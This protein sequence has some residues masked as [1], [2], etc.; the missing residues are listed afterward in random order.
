MTD[1]KAELLMVADLFQISGRGLVVMP[2]FSVPAHW[3]ETQ[4]DA[5]ILLPNGNSMAARL[6]LTVTH[7]NIPDLE[8]PSDLRWRVTPTFPDLTKRDVPI[9]SRVMI[10][11]N[12]ADQLLHQGPLTAP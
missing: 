10:D 3:T 5:S 8:T 9:G 7:F 2:D 1:E 6:N 12:I 4:T 11:A